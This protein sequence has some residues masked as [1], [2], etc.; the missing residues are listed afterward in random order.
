MTSSSPE[1]VLGDHVVE[2]CRRPVR[3]LAV[4]LLTAAAVV[5]SPTVAGAADPDPEAEC[6]YDEGFWFWWLDVGQG[7]WECEP[8]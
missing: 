8:D 6:T 2:R 3:R 7:S 5:L 1:L 4:G